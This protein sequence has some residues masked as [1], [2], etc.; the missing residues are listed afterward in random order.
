[1]IEHDKPCLS[2]FVSDVFLHSI[3]SWLLHDDKAMESS[4]SALCGQAVAACHRIALTVRLRPVKQEYILTTPFMRQCSLLFP[5]LPL[6][7][8]VRQPVKP[9]ANLLIH[10]GELPRP[11]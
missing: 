11:L 9:K 2:R 6:F 1:M 7:C 5:K 8:K 4:W 3:L 10:G